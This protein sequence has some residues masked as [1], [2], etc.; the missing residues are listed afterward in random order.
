MSRVQNS[1]AVGRHQEQA[2]QNLPECLECIQVEKKA[3]N[4]QLIPR[5]ERYNHGKQ[6]SLTSLCTEN[7][8]TH[9][10]ILRGQELIFCKI[11]IFQ[12]QHALCMGTIM[13]PTV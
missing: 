3:Q 8:C 11:R 10:Q 13:S 6:C 7:R 1:A 4:V 2:H 9:T 5:L 12:K